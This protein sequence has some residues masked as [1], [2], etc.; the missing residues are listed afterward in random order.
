MYNISKDLGKRPRDATFAE[1]SLAARLSAKSSGDGDNA[2]ASQKY[3]YAP[4]IIAAGVPIRQII[5]IPRNSSSTRD[6]IVIIVIHSLCISYTTLCENVVTAI[7]R[8]NFAL[9]FSLIVNLLSECKIFICKYKQFIY[10]L[11]LL[12]VYGNSFDN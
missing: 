2:H 1:Q 8:V 4:I 11:K 6:Q 3:R 7:S 10:F 9:R 12:L 5:L